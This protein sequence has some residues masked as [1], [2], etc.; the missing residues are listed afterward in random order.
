V[1]PVKYELGVYIAE[2]DILHNNY[3]LKNLWYVPV[4]RDCFPKAVLK[5]P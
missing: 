5:L 4:G 3:Y 1:S 2:D